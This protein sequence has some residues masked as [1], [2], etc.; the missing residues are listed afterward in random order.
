MR[1]TEHASQGQAPSPDRPAAVPR[2]P[3]RV[4]RLVQREPARRQRSDVAEQHEEL[5]RHA[6][7][8]AR[9]APRAATDARVARHRRLVRGV[10]PRRRLEGDPVRAQECVRRARRVRRRAC[11]RFGEHHGHHDV[12]RWLHRNA[13]YAV[14][15]DHL[16]PVHA[17]RQQDLRAARLDEPQRHGGGVLRRHDEA[18][19]EAARD[20]AAWGV[21]HRVLQAAGKPDRLPARRGVDLGG[22]P[23]HTSVRA[24]TPH[25]VDHRQQ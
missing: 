4:H 19:G 20:H 9:G 3:A 18:S 6:Q 8:R 14:A 13:P 23:C 24:R 12:R 2:V 11:Q 16:R 7:R 5:L 17:D 25:H 15:V 22:G 10:L 21:P 1:G